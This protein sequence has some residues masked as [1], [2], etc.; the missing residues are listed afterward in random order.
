LVAA[1]ILAP[2]FAANTFGGNL[3]SFLAPAMALSRWSVQVT[4]RASRES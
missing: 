1:A 4:V 3:T 2:T